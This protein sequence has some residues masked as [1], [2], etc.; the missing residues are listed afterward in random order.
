MCREY[1]PVIEAVLR[2]DLHTEA[3][4]IIAET[5]AKA[6][7]GFEALLEETQPHHGSL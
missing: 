3:E 2:T 4:K 1:E 6:E 7:A 5:V